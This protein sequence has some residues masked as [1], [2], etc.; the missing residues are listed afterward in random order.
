MKLST[1]RYEI[2]MLEK[3]NTLYYINY[4]KIDILIRIIKRCV[5]LENRFKPFPA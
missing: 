3:I 1:D 4:I 2:H 5:V